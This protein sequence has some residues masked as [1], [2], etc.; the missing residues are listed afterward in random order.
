VASYREI[1]SSGL[2][3]ATHGHVYGAN[4]GVRADAY[5]RGGGFLAFGHG[6]EH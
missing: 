1:V 5:L 3:G 4:L 2:R 6:E